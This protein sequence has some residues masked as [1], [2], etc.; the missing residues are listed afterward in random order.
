MAYETAAIL[1]SVLYTLKTAA[2]LEAATN[3]IQVMCDPVDVIAVVEKQLK[4]EAERA[5][6]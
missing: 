1:R 4:D 3:A 2:S 6:I 5:K